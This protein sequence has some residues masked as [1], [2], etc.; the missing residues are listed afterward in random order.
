[1]TAFLSV[2]QIQDPN[3]DVRPS[4]QGKVKYGKGH[5]CV[6]PRHWMKAHIPKFKLQINLQ[7]PILFVQLLLLGMVAAYV[8]HPDLTS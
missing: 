3:K 7:V 8:D 6:K 4:Q 1:M 5:P 2:N